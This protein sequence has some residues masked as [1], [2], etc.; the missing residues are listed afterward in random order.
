MSQHN[1]FREK[2]LIISR[3]FKAP[4]PLVFKA[5]SEAE[6]LEQ[7][8]GPKGFSLTVEQ[9]EFH[10]EGTFHYCI[11][12]PDDLKMW[13]KFVYK[14]IEPNTKIV[15]LNSFTD[16]NA[17]TIRAP[18]SETW[19]LEMYNVL[20]LEELNGNTTIQLHISPYNASEAE[21]NTFGENH[22]NM[23]IGFTGTFD[24]LEDYLLK[25]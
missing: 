21:V 12:S 23:E 24:R 2:E 15:F 10:P 9:L 17:N 20:T 25:N 5:W 16:E 8:W 13:G 3:T 11:Q 4:K 6:R 1:I 22:E 19:P 14:A 7:W 18:F